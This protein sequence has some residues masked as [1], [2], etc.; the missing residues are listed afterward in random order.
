MS[1]ESAAVSALTVSRLSD[2]GQSRMMYSKRSRSG[3]SS[4]FNAF[5]RSGADIISTSNPIRFTF[6]GMTLRAGMPPSWR[7]ESAAA[8]PSSPSYRVAASAALSIPRPEVAFAWGSQST[9]RVGFSKTA[10]EAD[11]LTAVVVLPTPPF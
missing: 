7:R 5:S 9:R 4:R 6:A 10:S 8:R 1:S 3:A 11:R 2:G